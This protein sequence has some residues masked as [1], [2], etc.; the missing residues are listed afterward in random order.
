MVVDNT[1][2]ANM[3]FLRAGFINIPSWQV[4]TNF[5]RVQAAR[6][7]STE[8]LR[9]EWII[10]LACLLVC[11]NPWTVP[12]RWLSWVRLLIHAYAQKRSRAVL[13]CALFPVIV[14]VALLP[15]VPVK[16]PSVHDEFSWLLMADTFCS[17]RLT[18]PTHQFWRHFETV[19]V[20]QKPTY[21]SMYPPAYGAFI[22]LGQ[23]FGNPWIGVLLS[24]GLMSGAIC[25][26]LQAW[27]PP[28]WAL[29][30]GLIASLQI[31][32]GSYWMNSY[33]GGAAAPAMAGALL[34]GAMPRF[35]R[36][37]RRGAAVIF[38]IAVVLL[39]NSRPFEGVV[40]SVVSFGTALLW[41]RKASLGSPQI[42]WPVFA[43]AALV[44][45]SGA[46]FTT[47]YCWRVTGN[48]FK[49]PYVVNRDTYG[50]PENLAILPPKQVNPRLAILKNMHVVELGNRKRYATF[51]RMLDSWCTRFVLLWEFFVGPGLTLPLLML[52]WTI[53]SRKLRV[54]FYIGLCMLGLNTLQLVGFPQ[55]FSPITA[56][57]FLFVTAG[58]RHIYVLARRRGMPGE[59]V[60]A[61]LVLY[62]VCVAA[63]T[64]FI[65]PLRI[66]PGT[67]WEWTHTASCDARAAMLSKLEQ[68]PG[69][70]VMF[71]RYGD[72]H[73]PH[74]E[75][76][77]NAA[78]VD[79]SKVVWA[80]ALSLQ[81]DMELRRYFTDRHAWIVEPDKDPNGFLPF[82]KKTYIVAKE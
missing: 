80:N 11:I 34:L 29:V 49:M 28:A 43:P 52:P 76:V 82:T 70:H 46:A 69:K 61:S 17:G 81:E 5:I 48:P 51:G 32:I 25:W 79:R 78:D 60:P 72:N 66:R 30:G 44:L 18:N 26:M 62:A 45:L 23:L 39:V 14:R 9:W 2:Q 10:L 6:P 19:H 55:H 65:E 68:L 54:V 7:F 53:R 31:G 58:M 71:V 16:P 15:A 77:Y 75:W 20:I 56:I 21:N 41:R 59:R 73:S 22:A 3:Q 24:V 50:W 8:L 64:L 63:L 33:V 74:E 4:L 37:P 40:L 12:S 35:L 57:I 38:A 13:T 36:K 27:M 42:R 1:Q 67:F 47:Y